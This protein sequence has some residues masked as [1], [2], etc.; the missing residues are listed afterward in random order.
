M[1]IPSLTNDPRERAAATVDRPA[2]GDV[3]LR[4][5]VRGHASNAT[6][7]IVVGVDGSARS[8]AAFDWAVR[9]ARLR[10]GSVRAVMAWQDHVQVYGEG[11]GLDISAA[12]HEVL[13]AAAA[14]VVA[15]LGEQ[16]NAA[17]VSDV[18]TTWEAVEG[19]PA[20]VLVAAADDADLL[21]V[22]SR[23][24][25]GFVGLLLGSVSQ[26]VLSHARCPIVVVPDRQRGRA[27]DKASLI[28]A[29]MSDS[30]TPPAVDASAESTAERRPD[31]V[32]L[33]EE[34]PGSPSRDIVEEWGM[35]SFPA[36]DPPANW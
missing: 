6:G 21:V 20:W 3:A 32:F 23:G 11:L 13:A 7:R 30:P 18:S 24:H 33:T 22:G 36:S 8:M 19:H 2:D 17:E 14:K 34:H 5:S 4:T 27:A 29:D 9:E 12:A 25:G 10:G 35:Q 28:G 31:P 15:R 1:P 16:L 26:H